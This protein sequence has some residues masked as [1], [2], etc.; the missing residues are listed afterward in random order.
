MLRGPHSARCQVAALARVVSDGIHD[1]ALL[2]Q[3]RT[4]EPHDKARRLLCVQ[5]PFGDS[6]N[7]ARGLGANAAGKLAEVHRRLVI[8]GARV[9]A[10]NQR[11]ARGHSQEAQPSPRRY[12]I[13]HCRFAP[14]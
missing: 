12:R 3:L 11:Q 6:D 10:T 1:G 9:R 14:L 8:V 7:P 4:S 13:Q 2:A 5:R